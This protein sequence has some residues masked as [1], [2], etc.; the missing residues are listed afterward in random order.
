MTERAKV[1]L[2]KSTMVYQ[3]YSLWFT[4]RVKNIE[5]LESTFVITNTFEKKL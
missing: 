1:S 5:T 4:D 3:L 2:H